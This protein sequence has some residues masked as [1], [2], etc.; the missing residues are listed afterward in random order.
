[1]NPTVIRSLGGALPELPKTTSG[2][3]A[4][5]PMELVAAAPMKCRRVTLCAGLMAWSP[6]G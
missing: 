5:I 4:G 2:T 3:I 1:M 6:L